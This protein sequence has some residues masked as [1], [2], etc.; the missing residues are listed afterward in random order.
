VGKAIRNSEKTVLR[1]VECSLNT[2]ERFLS[3][4]RKLEHILPAH[5]K[6]VLKVM[7]QGSVCSMLLWFGSRK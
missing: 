1:R 6:D 3:F 2:R 7:F 5:S 4:N